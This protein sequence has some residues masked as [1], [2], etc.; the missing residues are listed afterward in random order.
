[1][2]GR[3]TCLLLFAKCYLL[4]AYFFFFLLNANCHILIENFVVNHVFA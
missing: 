4:I 3:A 1:M 2:E